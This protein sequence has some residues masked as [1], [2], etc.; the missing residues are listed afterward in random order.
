MQPQRKYQPTCIMQYNLDNRNQ[1][2][3]EYS[4]LQKSILTKHTEAVHIGLKDFR[5]DNIPYVAS[6][7]LILT[8]HINA[9]HLDI[10]RVKI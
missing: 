10:K 1:S 6:H 7:K 3:K 2:L 4:T 5:C 8:H 9:F